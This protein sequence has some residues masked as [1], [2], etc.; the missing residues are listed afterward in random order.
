MALRLQ[1]QFP[2]ECRAIQCP[3]DCPIDVYCY[4][5]HYDVYIQG[6][7]YLH[8]VLSSIAFRNLA[9]L[10]RILEFVDSFKSSQVERFNDI[11]PDTQDLFTEEEKSIHSQEF[12]ED[13]LIRLKALKLAAGNMGRI[14][15][16]RLGDVQ[17]TQSIN[18]AKQESFTPSE[19]FP[20]NA[21]NSG[22]LKVN[23]VKRQSSAPDHALGSL[24][25]NSSTSFSLDTRV[26]S[27]RFSSAPSPP[28]ALEI[29]VKTD[30]DVA[31]ERATEAESSTESSKLDLTAH[32]RRRS[33]VSAPFS[34]RH[35]PLP[36]R[37]ASAQGV[38]SA[39][40]QQKQRR[41]E[42]YTDPEPQYANPTDQHLGGYQLLGPIVRLDSNEAGY[43]TVKAIPMQTIY[44]DN[45]LPRIP[46][47][48]EL[49]V[50]KNDSQ[51]AYYNRIEN[52]Q[53]QGR[54]GNR[55]SDHRRF[56]SRRSRQLSYQGPPDNLPADLHF[57]TN[58]RQAVGYR[59]TITTPGMRPINAIVWGKSN[60]TNNFHHPGAYSPL[61][62]YAPQPEVFHSRRTSQPNM[63]RR[64]QTLQDSQ[65]FPSDNRRGPPGP[66]AHTFGQ[67]GPPGPLYVTKTRPPMGFSNDARV[68]AYQEGQYR[69][70]QLSDAMPY[71]T[72]S[73]SPRY[74]PSWPVESPQTHMHQFQ[75]PQSLAI[76]LT[77]GVD[78]RRGSDR[79]YQHPNT[80]LD[81]T[82]Q[83]IVDEQAGQPAAT[84]MGLQFDGGDSRLRQVSSGGWSMD[85]NPYARQEGNEAGMPSYMP[86]NA[87]GSDHKSGLLAINQVHNQGRSSFGYQ[88]SRASDMLKNTSALR[89]EIGPVFIS[90]TS[91]PS[92]QPSPST[93][94][95]TQHEGMKLWVSGDE[96]DVQKET[97]LELFSQCGT[98]ED[99]VI[100]RP[101][102]YYSY[103]FILY[104]NDLLGKTS[105]TM[106]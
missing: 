19:A 6:S 27:R 51:Q 18:S 87:N 14:S 102:K 17:L 105:L 75:D 83:T 3:T 90:N 26:N 9:Q 41:R 44:A 5:D 30:V 37:V 94:N 46:Q 57:T 12:L 1:S 76:A 93:I 104:V 31:V 80:G 28:R 92:Y 67:P 66:G 4:F 73:D 85:T 16:Q 49:A 101:E 54:A 59:S 63:P 103:A 25:D 71:R 10:H 69:G 95:D 64:R 86:I 33:S 61:P 60:D 106:L 32:P 91:I 24:I 62:Y 48:G 81:M 89:P 34:P 65:I 8:E 47:Y 68:L 79:F 77:S 39:D 21:P 23:E 45:T 88:H 2:S 53:V 29:L 22:T 70:R 100:L 7:S 98:V 20:L 50:V 74:N 35:R 11:Y 52:V 40:I 72:V 84:P 96:T 82:N 13:A 78:S 97:L 15:E 36:Q 56:D 55:Q 38:Y 43:P 99:I 58:Q 42:H